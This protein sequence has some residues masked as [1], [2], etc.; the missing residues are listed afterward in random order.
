MSGFS[1]RVLQFKRHV[2][3]CRLNFNILK[4]RTT[5]GEPRVLDLRQ[6]CYPQRAATMVRK[7]G[8]VNYK[9]Q[10]LIPII[11]ELLPNGDYGWQAVA[12]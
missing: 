10:L 5:R 11:K 6:S 1:F 7:K 4:F 3:T 9:N 2:Q 8:A 12:A